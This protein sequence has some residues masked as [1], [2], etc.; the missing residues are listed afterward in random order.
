[1][2]FLLLALPVL[3]GATV[4]AKAQGR[5]R[6]PTPVEET[7][8]GRTVTRAQAG[9]AIGARTANRVRGF[10]AQPAPVVEAPAPRARRA[11]PRRQRG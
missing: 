6:Q 5:R 7:G 4:L 10:R 9:G 11:A 3:L 8:G 2:V 1:M